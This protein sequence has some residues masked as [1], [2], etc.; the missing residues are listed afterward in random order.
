MKYQLRMYYA[1][2]PNQTAGAKATRDCSEILLTA[3]FQHF[4]IPVLGNKNKL[5]SLPSL[6]KHLLHLI[7]ALKRGDVLLLQYPLL[8]VNKW[9]KWMLKLFKWKHCRLVCLVHDLDSLRQV[10]HA[11]TLQ[12]ELERLSGFD[13]VIVHNQ[14]MKSLLQDNGL[15]VKMRCLELFD[16]LLPERIRHLLIQSRLSTASAHGPRNRLVFAGN[17]GKSGFL[18]RLAEIPGLRFEL[19][20]QPLPKALFAQ[21]I[22]WAGA[23]DAD[24]LPAAITGDFGLIWDGPELESCSGYLGN[25]LN[26]NN[27]HKASLY[28]LALLPL[29]APTGSA[30]GN[31]IEEKRIGFTVSSMLELP[32]KIAAIDESAYQ[33]M[34]ARLPQIAADL[35]NGSFLKKQVADL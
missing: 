27:P 18:L 22:H 15:K 28:L 4:D 16:Y 21:N 6:L 1:D 24:E 9:L 7:W 20:G 5:Y 13:L 35:A 29:I 2:A 30:I 32:E 26:Y 10:H 23:F 19:Y 8:G 25:Y 17:L 33:Q 34:R 31:F 3:G 12:E 14:K 11:W